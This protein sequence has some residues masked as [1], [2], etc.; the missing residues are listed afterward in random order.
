MS[1]PFLIGRRQFLIT[2]SGCAAAA[3]AIGPGLFA[4]EAS[5]KR[6]AIGF[7]ALELD[8][9]VRGAAAIFAG[10]GGFIGRGARVSV[11]GTSGADANPRARRAVELTAHYSYLDGAERRVA[12]FRAW[13]SSRITGGQ[14]APITF[15]MPVDE[16]Q[17]LTF[18]VSAET[19]A[20]AG[21]TSRR[22]AL[23]LDQTQTTPLPLVLSVQNEEGSLK[24]ARGFYAVV[25]LY[26][27]DAEPRWGAYTIRNARGRWALVDEA[28]NAAPF[29]HFVLKI[30]Y[31]A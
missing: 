28:G 3:V 12:P 21:S 23:F 8:E 6:L 30:D 25:P 18:V 4:R 16:V 24:L 5:P 22:D 1:N 20:P 14:G 7:A 31:A 15:T 11:S 10:D 27:N 19:G 2:S 17:K 13:G 29:E 9:P 26:E